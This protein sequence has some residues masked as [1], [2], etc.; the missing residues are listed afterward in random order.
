MGFE[1]NDD[2]ISDFRMREKQRKERELQ[3][4]KLRRDE[5][6]SPVANKGKKRVLDEKELKVSLAPPL[7]I[8]KPGHYNAAYSW[9]DPKKGFVWPR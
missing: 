2:V 1:A 9:Q 3:M 5:K 6:K 7:K 8:N 4:L